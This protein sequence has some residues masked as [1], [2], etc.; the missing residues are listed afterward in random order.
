MRQI[1]KIIV[2]CSD[3]DINAHDHI[4]TI[5]RW[6][7]ERGFNGVGY[8]FFIRRNGDLQLGRPIEKPG[9]HAR[10]SNSYSIGICL[11]GR[12]IFT[13]GQLDTLKKLCKNYMRVFD[14]KVTDI[15]GHYE[16]NS[17]KTCPNLDM[18]KFREEL[19]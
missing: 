11:H 7:L 3:S 17:R 4:N 19:K 12:E 5:E 9:A 14:L 2:H 13:N 6:H 15:I 10:G 8:H 1:N 18:V 16:I